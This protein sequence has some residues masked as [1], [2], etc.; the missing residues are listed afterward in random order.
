[1]VGTCVGR[2]CRWTASV[3]TVLR[4]GQ[5]LED[6]SGLSVRDVAKEHENPTQ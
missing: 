2:A 6:E 4:G 3:S 1:M 5:W